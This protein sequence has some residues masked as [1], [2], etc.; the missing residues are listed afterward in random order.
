MAY[1]TNITSFTNF[2]NIT[3][4]AAEA[5]GTNIT[6]FTNSV[7]QNNNLMQDSTQQNDCNN[8]YDHNY[9]TIT[10]LLITI[11]INFL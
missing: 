9:I 1:S 3:L 5:Y 6:N 11:T 7:R 4:I 8:Y 10:W 2:T